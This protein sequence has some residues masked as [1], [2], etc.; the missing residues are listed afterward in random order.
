[1]PNQ[2]A[3]ETSPYLLQHKNNPVDWFPWGERALAKARSENKPIFLSIGYAACHWCHVMEHESFEDSETAQDLNERFVAIK[4]DREERPDLDQIYMSAVQQLTGQGGWPMSV[5]LTPEGKPFHGGTYFPPEPRMGMPSFRQVLTAVADAWRDR[6]ADLLTGAE[7]LTMAI[8]E[9]GLSDFASAAM[10]QADLDA[11]T[12]LMVSGHDRQHGG[13]GT[14]PKFPQ[15]MTLEY[16]LRRHL[17]TGEELPRAVIDRTLHSMARGGIYDQLGGGFHRY[18]VDA[19]WLVPH[20]EKMLYDN[21]QLAR[22]YVHAWQVTG[23]ALYRR[24]AEETLDYVRREMTH[25]AGGFYSTQDADSEGEEGKYFV[26]SAEE[27][28]QVLGDDAELFM[29]GYGV[30]VGGNWEGA[31]ILHVTRDPD[32]LAFR[33][34]LDTPA[35]EPK[36]ADARRRLLQARE[37]RVR[38]GLDDKIVTAWNGLMLAAF[39][40]A[41]RALGRDDYRATAI[42]AGEFALEHLWRDGGRLYRIWKDG[43]AKLNGYLED[44]AFLAEGF[45]ELYETTF[46]ER[47]FEA[48]RR[49]SD[50]MLEHFADPDGGFFDTSH[51]HEALLIRPRDLQDNATPS[52]NGMAVTVLTRMHALTADARYLRSVEA[53][54]PLVGQAAR[55]F[56]T[57]FGQWLVAADSAL[58]GA[59]EV[60]ITGHADD[61][62]THALIK[63]AFASYRPRQVV[64]AG[65][66]DHRSMVP[67]L[68]DRPQLNG[69]A[70][71]YVCQNF[72]CNMP[73]TEPAKLAE[74]LGA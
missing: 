58:G 59:R 14:A 17:A 71:A 50:S 32:V 5:F 26:W 61:A 45:I 28:R 64:A 27:V 57:A 3:N 43:E 72:V 15:P 19:E 53:A 35:I 60:A 30:S 36:L 56:P 23:D 52:G 49:L 6:P 12:S 63:T 74:Q 47:W 65:P 21:A 40:G 1:M 34:E 22:L 70:T 25:P 2:L 69:K 9:A 42:A 51:D 67:L 33:H 48:A 37:P 7:R 55:R 73:V 68:A 66:P 29:D 13:W 24:V 10:T 8:D 62:A 46:D 54:L 41:A 31:N 18:S 44:Y 16:L 4:V 20:F 11:A 39:A 38:P